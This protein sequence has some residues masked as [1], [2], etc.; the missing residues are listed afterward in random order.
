M[1]SWAVK[2]FTPHCPQYLQIFRPENKFHVKFAGENHQSD[3]SDPL[4]ESVCWSFWCEGCITFLHLEKYQHA[5]H[6]RV[7]RLRLLMSNSSHFP[8]I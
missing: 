8:K 5:G 7:F 2:D 6:K 1:R 4:L 3:V